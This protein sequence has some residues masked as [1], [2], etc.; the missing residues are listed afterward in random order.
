MA[1]DLGRTYINE[2]RDRYWFHLYKENGEHAFNALCRGGLQEELFTL[3][4][5]VT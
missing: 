5:F 3:I 1:L 4:S 2:T